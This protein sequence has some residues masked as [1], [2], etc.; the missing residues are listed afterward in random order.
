MSDLVLFFMSFL[1]FSVPQSSL[2]SQLLNLDVINVGVELS[3]MSFTKAMIV[4][5]MHC[6]FSFF[7][8]FS[9]FSYCLG[10]SW[11]YLILLNTMVVFM[12]FFLESVKMVGGFIVPGL[13]HVHFLVS[14]SFGLIMEMM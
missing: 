14:V 7:M 12:M 13:P 1:V 2:V 10:E 3:S 5:F 11:A 6:V 8:E 9:L 4:G